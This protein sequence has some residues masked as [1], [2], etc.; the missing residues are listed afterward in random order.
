MVEME[1]G[2]MKSHTIWSSSAGESFDE[3]HF[4]SRGL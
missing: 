1:E 2:N 3:G 4:Y